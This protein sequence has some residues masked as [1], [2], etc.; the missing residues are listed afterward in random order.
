M[1]TLEVFAEVLCPFAHVG[2]R[3][4][5]DRRTAAGLEEPLLDISR[6]GHGDFVIAWKRGAE[7]FLDQVLAA[8]PGAGASASP[9][10]GPA[11]GSSDTGGR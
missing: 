9:G 3:T 6:D 10:A 2:L 5:I 7:A 8:H 1:R 4:V 11:S